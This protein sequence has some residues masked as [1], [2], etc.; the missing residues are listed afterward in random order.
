MLELLGNV[1]SFS[2]NQCQQGR[3]KCC[4]LK[5]KKQERPCIEGL[6]TY[7]PVKKTLKADSVVKNLQIFHF[8]S[9]IEKDTL[10]AQCTPIER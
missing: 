1:S 8:C 3:R 4:L 6:Y 7:G 9:P 2:S 10:V 5:I